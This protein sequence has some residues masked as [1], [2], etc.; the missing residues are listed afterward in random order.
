MRPVTITLKNYRCFADSEPLRV[1]IGD[2]FTALVG[3]NNSG[4]T[5]LLR[6]FYELK[7]VLATATDVGQLRA[8]ATPENEAGVSNYQG[9]DDPLS[10]FHAANTRPLSI[11]LDFQADGPWDIVRIVLSCDRTSPTNWRGELYAGPTRTRLVGAGGGATSPD[12]TARFMDEGATEQIINLRPMLDFREFVLNNLYLAA[13]RN[14]ITEGSGSYYDL[15]IGTSFINQWNSWKTGTALQPSI[16]AQRL[17]DDLARLFGYERLEINRTASGDSLQVVV[18][19]RP[20]WLKELGAGFSQ[21]VVVLGNVAIRRPKYILIDEPELNLHPS[22][23]A[24]FLTSLAS[25]GAD[26]VAFATHSVGL[27]RTMAEHIYSF[28]LKDGCSHVRPFEGTDNLAAFLGEMSFS[29]FKELGHN[30]VLLVEGVHDIKTVQQ[31]LRLLHKEHEIV[32][33]PL[34]GRQMIRGSVQHELH[35]LTRITDS[36]AVLIDSE[37]EKQSA[38]L[39]PEL[40]AFLNDCQALAFAVHVTDLRAIENYFT[41]SAV[42]AVKGTKYRALGQYE[43]LADVTPVGGKHENWKIARKMTKDELMQTDVGKFLATL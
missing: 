11:Q 35:E 22:L 41:E 8:L 39:A 40:Q 27:A 42:Q 9:V 25:Y 15:S 7:F 16:D 43:R 12:G 34:G 18:N 10:I 4:K 1:E 13:F 37:R 21:F 24:D 5:S 20:Y 17:T 28:Q 29:S 2:G 33:L 23:Q 36:V 14:A 38:S 32:I 30:T 19:G 31:F 6:L 3:P 26:G